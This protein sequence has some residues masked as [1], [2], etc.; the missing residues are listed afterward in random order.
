M[1]SC[2][3]IFQ[4]HCKNGRWLTWCISRPWNWTMFSCETFWK[5]PI[6]SQMVWSVPVSFSCTD[7][8]LTA[9]I[10]P[11]S[12]LR[13]SYTFPNLPSP[14]SEWERERERERERE[15]HRGRKRERE[16]HVE[17][18]RELKEKF[19][20]ILESL[21]VHNTVEAPIKDTIEKKPL[22][23][24]QGHTLRSLLYI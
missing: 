22:Y 24:G 14:V 13:H 11:V 17:G 6:S 1:I 2:Y 4:R 18:E 23:K 12:R 20:I 21:L 9:I 19:W 7:I 8:C 15:I 5:I 16:I 3:I 10:S